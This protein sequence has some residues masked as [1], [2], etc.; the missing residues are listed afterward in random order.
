MRTSSIRLAELILAKN[1]Q[2]QRA[3]LLRSRYRVYIYIF[4][5]FQIFYLVV[6]IAAAEPKPPA[7]FHLL[8][9]FSTWIFS[10][11]LRCLFGFVFE[12]IVCLCVCYVID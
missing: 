5:V 7:S 11:L 3:N 12:A 9:S 2:E 8:L 4:Y 6:I 1:P 10:I